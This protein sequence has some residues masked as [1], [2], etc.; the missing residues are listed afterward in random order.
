MNA[1]C[2]HAAQ[3]FYKLGGY[4]QNYRIT[5]EFCAA[6]SAVQN[7]FIKKSFTWYKVDCTPPPLPNNHTPQ[8]T[9]KKSKAG[10]VILYIILGCAVGSIVL[11]V[12]GLCRSKRSKSDMLT[13]INQGNMDYPSVVSEPRAW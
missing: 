7:E 3:A 12:I 4:K 2:C 11:V 9:K 5:G 13:P 6:C 8:P 10:D 1:R